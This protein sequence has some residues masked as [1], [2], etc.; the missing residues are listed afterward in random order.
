MTSLRST[1]IVLAMMRFAEQTS[2]AGAIVRGVRTAHSVHPMAAPDFMWQEALAFVAAGMLIVS[3][4]Q[5]RQY[6]RFYWVSLVCACICTAYGFTSGAWPLGFA[7][8]AY[9]IRLLTMRP[10]RHIRV[11]YDNREFPNK[12]SLRWEEPSRLERLFGIK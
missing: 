2:N 11:V 8:G 10:R 12:P 4:H 7:I 6:P 3:R 9:T 5:E 1:S